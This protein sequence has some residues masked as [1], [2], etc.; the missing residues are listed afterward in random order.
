MLRIVLATARPQALEA[1]VTALSS[2]PEVHV[3]PVDRSAAALE[4]TR[5]AAPQLVIIDQ[6]LKDAKPLE[7]VQKLLRVNAMVNTAVVSP[8]SE[9]EFHEA[10]EGLGVL[11]R[12]PENPGASEAGALLHKLKTVLGL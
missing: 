7:L 8:L 6:G 3:Q 2:N 4:A 10:S 9:D 1:F 12:L 5:T 11:A